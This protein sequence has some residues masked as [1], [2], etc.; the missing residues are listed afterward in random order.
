MRKIGAH[1]AAMTELTWTERLKCPRCGKEGTAELCEISQ[2]N[3]EFRL[4]PDGFKVI[5]NQYGSDFQCVTCA[6][7][8][9]LDV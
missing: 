6:T 1:I 5:T 2:F 8:A 3:N 7:A 4:I 9:A